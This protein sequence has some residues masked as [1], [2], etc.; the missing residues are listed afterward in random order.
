[1]LSVG[2]MLADPQTKARDMVVETEHQRLGPVQ[3]I[4]F[5]VKFSVTPAAIERGA[6][7]LGQHTTE[8]LLDLGYSNS[9]IDRLADDDVVIRP[10]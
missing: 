5:P 9:D 2:E 7:T 1:V 8:V 10:E 6:P 4:G 3:T